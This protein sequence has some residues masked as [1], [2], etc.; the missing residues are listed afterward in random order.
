MYIFRYEVMGMCVTQK[1]HPLPHYCFSAFVNRRKKRQ[2]KKEIEQRGKETE[3]EREMHIHF[4]IY[5][6]IYIYDIQIWN[7][8]DGEARR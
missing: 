3:R 8:V 5:M 7:L 1:S 6:C 4:F 2:T